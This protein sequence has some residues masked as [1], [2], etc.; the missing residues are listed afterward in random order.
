MYLRPPLPVVGRSTNVQRTKKRPVA[1]PFQNPLRLFLHW[2][3]I[4][5]LLYVGIVYSV[6]YG[7]LASLSVLIQEVYPYLDDTGA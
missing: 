2:D 1:R 5:I 7:V 4:L 3:V 6:M